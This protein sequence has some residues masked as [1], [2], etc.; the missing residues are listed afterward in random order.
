LPPREADLLAAHLPRFAELGFEVEPFGGTAFVIR[1]LPA[2]LQPLL[3]NP[4]SAAPLPDA[5]RLLTLLL[6]ELQA[7]AAAPPET[8]RD[9]LAQKAACACAVKKGDVLSPA[10]MQTLL[11]DLAETWSPAACPHGRPVFVPLTLAELE[12]RFGRR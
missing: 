10:Q 9:R 8:Q 4:V 6:E 11:N 2:L 12:R 5:A 1:R 7:C 3:G